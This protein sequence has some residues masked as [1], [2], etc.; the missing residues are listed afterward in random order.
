MLDPALFLAFVA[1][2][3]LL[4]VTPGPDMMLVLARGVGQGR[5]SPC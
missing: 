3:A 5:R 4:E 2:L 1:A